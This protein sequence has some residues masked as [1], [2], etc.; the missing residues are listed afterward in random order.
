MH[1]MLKANPFSYVEGKLFDDYIND[2]K[3]T[4]HFALLNRQA[5]ADVILEKMNWTAL[6]ASVL[7]ITTL[8]QRI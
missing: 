6:E 3:L 7:F 5:M 2:M 4:Q 1:K 8:I